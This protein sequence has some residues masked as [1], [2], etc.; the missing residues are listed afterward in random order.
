MKQ[1]E[2]R[3]QELKTTAYHEKQFHRNRYRYSKQIV[4]DTFGKDDV[5]PSYDKQTADRFYT[6]TYSQRREIDHTQLNWFPHLPTSPDNA[7]FTQFN[8]APIRPRDIRSVLSKSNKKSAPGPDGI[9]YNTL[10]KLDCTHHALATL[11]NK[12]LTSGAHPPSWGESVVKLLYKKGDS[13]DPSNFRMI[14]LTGCIG[15]TYHLILS[16]RLSTYLTSNKFIDPTLQKAF[17]PGINGCIEH[18]AIMEEIIKDAKNKNRTCHITFFDLE[19]A[20]GSVPHTLIDSTLERNHLPENIRNYF[21]NLY[22]HST[23]VVQTKSFRSDPFTFR[24]GVFQGDPLSPIVFLLVF[25][26]ILQELQNQSHKGYKL[27]DVSHISLPYADDFCLIST[28][29]KT[30]QNL[31][32]KIHTQVNSMGMKLKPSK[33]RSFSLCAG[34]P[35]AVPFHIGDSDVPSIR[36]EEQKFLGKLLFFHGKPEET[37]NLVKDTFV[38]GI[39]NIDKAMV[40][41][42]YKL[43]IYAKYFLPSKRFLLTV[44]TL[45]KTQ[46]QALDT[47]T[48][49]AIKR[50]VGLPRSATNA[51][52]HMPQALDIKS[53][54]QLYTE[55]HTVSHVRTR[56]QGDATVNAAIDCTL[57]REGSWTTKQ[58]TTVQCEVALDTAKDIVNNAKSDVPSV[59]KKCDYNKSVKSAVRKH[60]A[61]EHETKCLEKVKALV[62]Q[63]KTLELAAAE[64]TD[65]TWKSFVYDLRRGTLKFLANAHIDTL[66]TAANL[67]RWKKS[68][69]DKCKLCKG[70]QTTA[71]CLNICKV[72]METGR[73]TWRHNNIVN[74]V[75]QSLDSSKYTVFSDIEGHEAPGGGTVPP[76]VTV[77]NLKPDITIWDKVNNKFHIFELTV[78]L[79]VNIAQRNTDKSNKYAH[80]VTDITHIKTTVT[81]F[82]ISSLGNV[83]SENKKRLTSLHK[84]CKPGIKLSM[85]V[86][87][88]SSLSIYSSYHIWLCR[89]DPEFVIPPF[90]P[91]PFQSRSEGEP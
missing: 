29:L 50:W 34:K 66:P 77:T 68:S 62:V 55:M 74:Y 72:A 11:F 71:H 37:F 2:K 8:N 83:S 7:D 47:L 86:K 30:H 63:G 67:K 32:N 70:R 13:A 75:V 17:L 56:L 6:S 82:E 90:L 36:D 41:E 49:K 73:W 20:F 18:N 76:E 85:F 19:D 80:F 79:D 16:E 15:K 21:H 38:D 25:N 89:N 28:N 5:Q 60:M 14:A 81:A 23:A 91:A 44:H 22:T 10:L 1:I 64:S 39:A 54:S 43:W 51:V 31:I 53:I 33:C 9:T 35:T 24:R 27:G 61:A 69:S 65:F 59:S 26:P 52:I 46:L 84:F 78:P 3:K 40:R 87:N 57:E 58:S 4:S 88:I 42:E 45:T 12:V 48:D